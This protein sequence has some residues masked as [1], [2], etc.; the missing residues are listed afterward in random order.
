M[1]EKLSPPTDSVS[2]RNVLK[3]SAG[4][5]AL[6]NTAGLSIASSRNSGED[7]PVVVIKG[8]QDNPISEKEIGEG[9]SKAREQVEERIDNSAVRTDPKIGSESNNLVGHVVT[10]DESGSMHHYSAGANSEKAT[11]DAHRKLSRIA[12]QYRKKEF[13]RGSSNLKESSFTGK[14]S[15]FNTLGYNENID[16]DWYFYDYGNFDEF[17]D[18]HGVVTVNYD[19]AHLQNEDW[20]TDAYAIDSVCA[21]EPGYSYYNSSWRGD[22][23][24]I[25]HDYDATFT[26]TD[27]PELDNFGPSSDHQEGSS[28]TVSAGVNN[29]G[30][31]AGFSWNYD[32][33][34]GVEVKS[35]YPNQY[36][37]WD[38]QFYPNDYCGQ[39]YIG[40]VEPGSS[41]LINQP[42]SGSGSQALL[43]LKHEHSFMDN[44]CDYAVP[45]YETVVNS[46]YPATIDY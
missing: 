20:S 26:E 14:S 36:G 11:G 41:V 27:N 32:P 12:Q 43:K 42:S 4:A 37:K 46:S 21:V 3:I 40:Q 23:G 8:D 15:G 28:V 45:P 25:L 33:G 2:R 30:V 31:S 5:T 16:K 44:A 29:G 22:Y 39:K 38:T 10:F 9:R 24:T 35:S 19:I 34:I 6:I 17:S 7:W 13:N 18:P 1:G